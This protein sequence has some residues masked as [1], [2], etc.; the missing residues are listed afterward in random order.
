M[1]RPKDCRSADKG[2]AMPA[3]LLETASKGIL[4]LAVF[5]LTLALPA[6]ARADTWAIYWYLCGSN[7]ETNANAASRDLLEVLEADLSKDVS[8]II[9]TGGSKKWASDD[10]SGQHPQRWQVKDGDIEKLADLPKS[11]MGSGK[12]LA[13]FI[14]YC[15]EKHPADHRVL[16][17]WD[18]GAGSAGD[19][20]NDE[21]YGMEGMSL[22]DLR[23]VLAEVC[24]SDPANPPFEIIGFDACLMA[25]IDVAKILHGYARY[26]V[27]SQNEE[28]GV[29][30][31]YEKMLN[32]LSRKT[33]MSGAEFGRIICDTYL[34]DCRKENEEDRATL[35]LTDLSKVPALSAAW[36]AFGIE[37]IEKC[38][39]DDNLPAILA[40]QANNAENYVNSKNEG[41]S[42]MADMGSFVRRMQSHIDGS[43]GLVLQ[44]L[45]NAVLYKATGPN[46]KPTGLSF[47]YPYDGGK[48]FGEMKKNG[49]IT[50]L[51][52]L[53]GA[54]LGKMSDGEI[55]QHLTAIVKE[56][57]TD[58]PGTAL[59]QGNLPRPQ[60]GAETV[61]GEISHP[62]SGEHGTGGFGSGGGSHPSGTGLFGHI[63]SIF[64][65]RE[66]GTS[67]QR[68]QAFDSALHAFLTALKPVSDF[69]IESLEDT[70]VSVNDNGDAVM[71][72]TQ[73]QMRFVSSVSCALAYYSEEDD[74]VLT[75]GSDGNVDGDW[76]TG[77]FKDNYTNVW[78]SI[79]GHL[80]S[81]ELTSTDEDMNLYVIPI[82]L[83]GERVNLSAK[84]DFKTEKYVVLEARRPTTDGRPDRF[85]T[86]LRKGDR[87][88]TIFEASKL[89][90]END[91]FTERDVD[92]FVLTGE[93]ELKDTD[94]GDGKFV[95]MFEMR[96]VKGE[97]A[98]S[99]PAY[100]EVKKGEIFL[101]EEE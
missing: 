67:E 75:L 87:I 57:D 59:A 76:E 58:S 37:A 11:S 53:Q 51:L 13:E 94:L 54:M 27:A 24:K 45:D 85:A 12:T 91:E 2:G 89:S 88:T 40:R 68:Q 74:I 83:N 10:F 4:C 8:V 78:P 34:E 95:Y 7:L 82:K 80:V 50:S 1:P 96:D 86:R 77:V 47:Y 52:V 21:L 25:T 81:L 31:S 60:P 93:P 20:A 32:S 71:K 55:E 6:F 48:T 72:L 17:I 90:D 29:G 5:L 70:A 62:E 3:R 63:G 44:A 14:R 30:W 46:C 16:I 98:L 35:S 100:I 28:P 84:Y 73:E 22:A 66:N 99:K 79:E 19:F 97:S 65:N 9:Q 38:L 23:K 101:S 92:T 36:N 15:N 33:S 18:H 64:G 43:A 42:N 61:H 41:Y 56:L 39:A 69:K 26:M 49:A